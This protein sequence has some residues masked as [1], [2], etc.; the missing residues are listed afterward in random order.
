MNSNMFAPHWQMRWNRSP[1]I[2]RS[3]V[4]DV[5]KVHLYIIRHVQTPTL[6]ALI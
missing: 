1:G 4:L 2:K 5:A 3:I 6:V